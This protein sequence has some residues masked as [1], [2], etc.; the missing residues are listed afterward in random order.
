MV[1]CVFLYYI[2]FNESMDAEEVYNIE[3]V[4]EKLFEMKENITNSVLKMAGNVVDEETRTV[5]I[6]T[7]GDI[8]EGAT[9]FADATKLGITN[10]IADIVVKQ[11]TPTSSISKRRK[12]RDADEEDSEVER[13]GKTPA[14][15]ILVL[16]NLQ[17]F[18]ILYI[19]Q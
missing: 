7:M 16:Y 13:S 5:V 9:Q 4:D 2:V 6:D 1:K 19:S 17:H 10:T 8:T 3:E 11:V 14:E 18:D 15:V 12:R